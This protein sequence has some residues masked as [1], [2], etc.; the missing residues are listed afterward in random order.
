MVAFG[1]IIFFIQ[2]G[3]LRPDGWR[4][5]ININITFGTAAV[6]I[7]GTYGSLAMAAWKDAGQLA[8]SL[9]RIETRMLISKG[10]LKKIR[11]ASITA[12]TIATILVRT[13]DVALLESFRETSL[14]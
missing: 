4:F 1:T 10:M 7:A 8:E 2:D 3:M 13:V 9:R 12:V 5:K 14:K 6:Q 11:I